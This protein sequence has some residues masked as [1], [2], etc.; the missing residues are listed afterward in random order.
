MR[1]IIT[2]ECI[3]EDGKKSI[4]TLGTVERTVGSTT[5][6]NVGVHLQESKQILQRLQET[7]V[8]QQLE[9]DCEQKRKCSGCGTC[10]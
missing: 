10:R 1:W 4:V 7:V 9:E 5:A 6:E 2:M 3:G 8:G